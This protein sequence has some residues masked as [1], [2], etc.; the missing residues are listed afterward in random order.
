MNRIEQLLGDSENRMNSVLIEN[1]KFKALMVKYSKY[2]NESLG[3]L[4]F[5]MNLSL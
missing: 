4:F 5:R 2:P 1:E 3:E